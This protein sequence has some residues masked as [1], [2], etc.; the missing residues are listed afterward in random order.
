MPRTIPANPNTNPHIEQMIVSVSI[1]SS[2]RTNQA[3][4]QPVAAVVERNQ[5]E[6]MKS[7]NERAGTPAVAVQRLVSH[8]HRVKLS[9]K[10]GWKLPPNTVVVARPTKWGNPWKV[11]KH[12]KLRDLRDDCSPREA[13]EAYERW[14]QSEGHGILLGA[15]VALRGKNLAC[16]CPLDA[17]CHADV[18]L[19]LANDQAQAQ[20]PGK[21]VERKNDKQ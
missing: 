8:P 6:Q 17:P 13:V 18:L 7:D 1:Y 12:K 2:S 9:R 11:R 14:L 5:K 16:W 19:R 4:P 10:K 20:P 15:K 3:H 21:V